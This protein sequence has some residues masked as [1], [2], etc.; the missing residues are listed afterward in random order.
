MKKSITILTFIL[1]VNLMFAQKEKTI[2]L[3]E[4]M[5]FTYPD[6]CI[7]AKIP[8]IVKVT[9][10]VVNLKAQ[11]IRFETNKQGM[12]ELINEATISNIDSLIFVNDTIG[13]TLTIDYVLKENVSNNY[14]EYIEPGHIKAVFKI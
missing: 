3:Q 11:N 5:K 13:Y 9:F 1:L 8:A 6:M 14:I 10:D 7:K 4:S 12:F 2:Y